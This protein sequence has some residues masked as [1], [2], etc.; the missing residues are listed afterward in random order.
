MARRRVARRQPPPVGCAFPAMAASAALGGPRPGASVLAVTRRTRRARRIR[1]V[2]VQRYGARTIDDLCGGSVVAYGRCCSPRPIG[3]N[4]FFWRQAA[5]MGSPRPVAR[6]RLGHRSGR[7]SSLATRSR[8][9]WDRGATRRFAPAADA[10]AD[11]NG[12]DARW[13][14]AGGWTLE[15]GR[16]GWAFPLAIC[17]FDQPGPVSSPH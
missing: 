10:A 17:A 15:E 14:H 5:E 7:A 1:I 4:E 9:T 11:A 6:S 8:S 2:A 13:R 3:R 16:C 12:D